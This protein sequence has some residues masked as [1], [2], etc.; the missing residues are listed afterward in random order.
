MKQKYLNHNRYHESHREKPERME[1]L[2]KPAYNH[3][4]M[5]HGRGNRFRSA[6]V[7]GP[8]TG[9]AGEGCSI[10]REVVVLRH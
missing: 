6:I 7:V 4:R 10:G 5:Q 3:K 2:K 8:A 1:L 9:K